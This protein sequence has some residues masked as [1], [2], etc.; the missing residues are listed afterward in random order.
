[1]QLV[2]WQDCGAMQFV[3][4]YRKLFECCSF[5]RLFSSKLDSNDI[6]VLIWASRQDLTSEAAEERMKTQSHWKRIWRISCHHFLHQNHHHHSIEH[7][8]LHCRMNVF[9]PSCQRAKKHLA[10]WVHLG[11]VSLHS[12]VGTE[13]V[14]L[15]SQSHSCVISGLGRCF[16][17]KPQL[18]KGS[19]VLSRCCFCCRSEKVCH[20]LC[21]LQ[22]PHQCMLSGCQFEPLPVET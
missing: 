16:Q 8:A 21:P 6:C 22:C 11:Q 17:N 13:L 18:W 5:A 10:I 4:S 9:P 1:M 15:I 7:D 2:A 14:L 20:P 12:S 3:C 19:L